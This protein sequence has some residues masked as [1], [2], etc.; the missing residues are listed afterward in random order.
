M[1]PNRRTLLRG[2]AGIGLLGSAGITAA[3]A[4]EDHESDDVTIDPQTRKQ[5]KKVRQATAKYQDP[6]K[7][8]AD[9]YKPE[10]S[11]IPNPNGEGAMG[12]HFTNEELLGDGEVNATEPE[13]LVYEPT[14]EGYDLV[15]VEYLASGELEEPPEL[16]GQ[17]FNYNAHLGLY[18][19]HVWCW[20]SNPNG[21]FA[22]FNP[23]VSC[24]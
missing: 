2:I 24:E 16:F 8:K 20:R 13:A 19:L 9:G 21:M 7:A 14:D 10:H 12:V 17:T 15:A 11:C 6:E 22:A 5:L 1:T 18:T 3:H 23:N 4:G